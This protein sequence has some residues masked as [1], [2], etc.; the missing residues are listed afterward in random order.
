MRRVELAVVSVTFSCPAHGVSEQLRV[1]DEGKVVA[2][3]GDTFP[4]ACWYK[5]K[6]EWFGETDPL[7]HEQQRPLPGQ[8]NL[9]E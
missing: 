5:L 3:S 9:F 8:R 1:Y 4:C 2:V 7:P 6:D